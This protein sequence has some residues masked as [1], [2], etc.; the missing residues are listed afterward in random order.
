VS[1]LWSGPE[2]LASV[3]LRI[4]DQK[5]TSQ[6]ELLRAA[7]VLD[8]M[9]YHVQWSTFTSGPPM[10]EAVK[11]GAIDAGQVGNTPRAIPNSGL[12]CTANRPASHSRLPRWPFPGSR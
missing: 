1:W 11:A 12:S 8:D 9:P 3:T 5:G 4:G 2:Q 7:G 6:R 10:L